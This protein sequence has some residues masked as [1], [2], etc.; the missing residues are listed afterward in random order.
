MTFKILSVPKNQTRERTRIRFLN[1][2]NAREKV[3]IRRKV[4]RI[5]FFDWVK[6]VLCPAS[7]LSMNCQRL[8]LGQLGGFW[9]WRGC[10]S[11]EGG[12]CFA[13]I[14]GWFV[15]IW[16]WKGF[17]SD[18]GVLSLKLKAGWVVNILG[19]SDFVV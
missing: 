9:V 14:V 2:P 11:D 8:V 6:I 1:A 17:F 13:Q 10:L 5:F 15:D 18:E 16:E 7:T 3:Y 19:W 12:T 4:P